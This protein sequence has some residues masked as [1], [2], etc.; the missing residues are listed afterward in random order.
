[1]SNQNCVH[2]SIWRITCTQ[3][4]T[5]TVPIQRV[6]LKYWDGGMLHTLAHTRTDLEDKDV[7]L[8]VQR[9]LHVGLL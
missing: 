7:Q 4:I 2:S 9:D 6:H 1:M 5:R 8:P 3:A